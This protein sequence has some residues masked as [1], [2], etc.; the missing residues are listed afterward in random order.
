MSHIIGRDP[1]KIHPFVPAI[2]RKLPE[3]EQLTFMVE[4]LPPK[5]NA[6]LRD[7]TY[8]ATGLGKKR[9]EQF[10]TGTVE[11]E[12][13]QKCLKGWNNFIDQDGNQVPFNIAKIGYIPGDILSE[14]ANFARGITDEDDEDRPNY[15]VEE[16]IQKIE[17]G[18]SKKDK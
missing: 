12:V 7:K 15:V 10:L 13:I 16:E 3:K 1:D 6:E 2:D 11:L 5:D 8:K 17:K 4:M 9:S 18:G 14:I